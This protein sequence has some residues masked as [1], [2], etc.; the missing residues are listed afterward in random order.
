MKDQWNTRYKDEE[1]V[2]GKQP[3]E[4]FKKHLD[5]IPPGK[6]F[7]PAEGEGRNAIY[8]ALKGWQ[9][10]A[11]DF[12]ESGKEKAIKLAGENKVT[13]NYQVS[14]LM[15]YQFPENE[16]DAVGII[17]A[18]FHSAIRSKIYRKVAN[19]LKTGGFLILETFSKKQLGKSSGGPQ[20]SEMLN[21]A[22]LIKADFK[23]FEII[24]LT[25]TK[26]ILQ[27]GG[28]H[29]GEAEVVRMLA[30]RK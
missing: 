15:E 22:E 16:Y 28:L 26:I 9:V 24:Q 11:V 5:N 1:F 20:D 3:N 14:D 6:L 18:H 4:Y 21:S 27:E 23:G 13:I 12:S 10:D 30:R 19:S 7:L 2:Y 29:Q 25:E 17:Y 8:A